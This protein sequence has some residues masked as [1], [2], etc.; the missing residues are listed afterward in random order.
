MLE[1]SVLYVPIL[2]STIYVDR[3]HAIITYNFLVLGFIFIYLYISS[4]F[5]HFGLSDKSTW[6]CQH[7]KRR[8]WFP[9]SSVKTLNI[10]Y[11]NNFLMQ[12]LDLYTFLHTYIK[13]YSYFTYALLY[14]ALY[15]NSCRSDAC[16]SF[17]NERA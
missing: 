10:I 16:R 5:S 7:W 1:F 6:K 9:Y 12:N 13:L 3:M 4:R 2:L 15:F 14:I 8:P 17:F 11:R